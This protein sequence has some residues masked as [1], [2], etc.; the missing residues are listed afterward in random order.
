MHVLKK[1]DNLPFSYEP[2]VWLISSQH[3]KS[4]FL[5]MQIE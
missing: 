5:K 2:I 4:I 1:N 3:S